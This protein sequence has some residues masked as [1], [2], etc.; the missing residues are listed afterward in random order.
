MPDLK[1]DATQVTYSIF[2][3]MARS[4]ATNVGQWT[5]PIV[6]RPDGYVDMRTTGRNLRLRLSM[7]GPTVQP[8]TLG[9]HLGDWAVRGD[10]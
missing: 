2:S 3:S 7:T 1:G 6:M 4:G 10:R 8:F 9:E 5:A